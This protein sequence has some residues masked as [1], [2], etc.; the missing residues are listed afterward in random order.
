MLHIIAIVGNFLLNN[1]IGQNL[2]ASAILGTPAIIHLRKVLKEHHAER[3]A[4]ATTHHEELKKVLAK[5]HLHVLR[6][7]IHARSAA[8]D[9]DEPGPV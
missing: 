3:L 2:T 5:T 4:L 7:E 9:S 6:A 1:G 8:K